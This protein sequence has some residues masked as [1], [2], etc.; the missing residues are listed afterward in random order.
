MAVIAPLGAASREQ[1]A[2]LALKSAGIGDLRELTTQTLDGI[3]IEPLYGGEDAPAPVFISGF[4]TSPPAIRPLVAEPTPE[5]A[6]VAIRGEIAGG[7]SE[8]LLQI[9]A[10]GMAGVRVRR[11]SDF[12]RVFKG[13]NLGGLAIHLRQAARGRT[14][15]ARRLR[16]LF[17]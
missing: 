11:A 17:V 2:A 4:P 13:I 8:I 16:G 7:A 14:H 5:A 12:E 10:P 9:E 3:A 15:H 6:N 1:W